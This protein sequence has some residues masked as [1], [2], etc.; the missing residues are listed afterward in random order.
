MGHWACLVAEMFSR[1]L[2]NEVK[3]YLKYPVHRMFFDV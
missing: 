1:L 3:E 2:F